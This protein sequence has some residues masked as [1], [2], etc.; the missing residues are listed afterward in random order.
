LG[1]LKFSFNLRRVRVK[2]WDNPIIIG[3]REKY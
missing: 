2:Y 1:E 3:E